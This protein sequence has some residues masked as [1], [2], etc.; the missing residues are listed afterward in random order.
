MLSRPF[1]KFRVA[2]EI[3]RINRH[4]SILDIAEAVGYSKHTVYAWLNDAKAAPTPEQFRDVM[5]WTKAWTREHESK[6]ARP[7]MSRKTRKKE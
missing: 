1:R 5:E 3:R 2:A 6:Q 4:V 7:M